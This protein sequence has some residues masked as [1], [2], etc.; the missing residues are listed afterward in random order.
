MSEAFGRK[1]PPMVWI[2]AAVLAVATVLALAFLDRT[3]LLLNSP[4]RIARLNLQRLDAAPAGALRVVAVGSS[5]TLHAIEYDDVFAA[6]LGRPQRRVDFVRIAV[7]SP[8]FED[9]QPALAALVRH[10]PDVLLVEA[11]MLLV[12]RER[13]WSPAYIRATARHHLLLLLARLGV[14][15]FSHELRG[16]HG[17]DADTSGLACQRNDDPKLLSDYAAQAMLWRT[18]STNAL[19]AWLGYLRRLHAAG[20]QVILLDVPRAPASEAAIPAAMRERIES[21][22]TQIAQREGFAF[23]QPGAMDAGMFCDLVHSNTNGR[24]FFS[25]WLGHRLNALLGAHA[26]V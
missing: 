9:L 14:G 12:D 8:A 22:R 1:P 5:K 21:L 3:P 20:T 25:D 18:S 19:D 24:A 26:G 17:E 11:E 6:R 23:W 4:Y 13:P 16:N 2:A 7:D 15:T 10:P